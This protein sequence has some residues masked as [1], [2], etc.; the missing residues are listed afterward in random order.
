MDHKENI[1][2]K[3]EHRRKKV[4]GCR[5]TKSG[6]KTKRMLSGFSYTFLVKEEE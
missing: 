1:Y 3:V 6:K 5:T 4:G 2:K